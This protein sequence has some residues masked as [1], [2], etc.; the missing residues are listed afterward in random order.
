MKKCIRIHSYPRLKTPV[1]I[2]AWHG[3]GQVALNAGNN[4]LTKLRPRLFADI[5]GSCFF[6]PT[7]VTVQNRLIEDLFFYRGEFYCARGGARRSDLIIFRADAQPGLDRACEYA[8][9]ILDVAQRFGVRQVFT[10]AAKPAN[11]SHRQP[12]KV[13]G[14]ATHP[15]LLKDLA[16]AGIQGMSEGQIMGLNGLFLGL[17]RERDMRGI[18]LLAEIPGHLALMEQPRAS[19]AVLEALNWLLGLR[20]DLSSFA[21]QVAHA[22]RNIDRWIEFFRSRE[23]DMRPPLTEEE[24]EKLKK[25]LTRMTRMPDEARREIERLFAEAKKDMSKA[26]DLKLKLDRWGIF[27]EYEDR[28]LDLFRRSDG[29]EN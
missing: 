17:A 3:M 25:L 26:G 1:M 23:E 11:I 12:S 27:K 4:L 5:D 2:A 15:E 8:E 20:L 22:E 18:C 19:L 28:F 13:W 10:F 21:D 29:G 14:V 7:G 6:Y 16:R 9:A 24:S